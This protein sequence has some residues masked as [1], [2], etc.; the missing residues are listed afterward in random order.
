M[1]STMSNIYAF[2]L[3]VT[4]CTQSCFLTQFVHLPALSGFVHCDLFLCPLCSILICSSALLFFYS[5]LLS[6]FTNALCLRTNR[7][8][9]F[10]QYRNPTLPSVFVT[11]SNFF[12]TTK[13]KN[14]YIIHNPLIP[15]KAGGDRLSVSFAYKCLRAVTLTQL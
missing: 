4:F 6:V 7:Q 2:F 10:L 14:S 13:K 11:H 9:I 1:F 8:H 12:F 3:A 5:S 15:L